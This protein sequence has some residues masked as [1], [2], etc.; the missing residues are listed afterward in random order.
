[1]HWLFLGALV[2][3]LLVAALAC[4]GVW[5]Y[6]RGLGRE[7]ETTTGP[8]AVVILP[9]RGVPP[10]LD[11]LWAALQ[12]Q[13]YAPWRLI[14]AVE[15]RDDPAFAALSRLV[16]DDHAPATEIVVA[17]LASDT[18]QK[19]HN[20]LAA[21]GRLQPQDDIVVFA[22]A[23]IVPA[24][25]WLARLVKP[26]LDPKI[27][28]VSGYRWFMPQDQNL[29]S[30]FVAVCNSSICTLP[31]PRG[32]SLAW[33]GSMAL[34]RTTLDSLDIARW[35]R[36]SIIDDL[37]LGRAV[38]AAGGDVLSPRELLVPSPVSYSWRDGI[39]FGRRQYALLRVYA[40]GHWLLAGAATTV[41]VIG[42]V[43]GLSLA[44][45]G[46]L[47]AIAVVVGVIALDRIRAALRRRVVRELWG[48]SAPSE[49]RRTLWL[50]RWATPF[51][52]LFHAAIVWSSLFQRNIDWGGRT[53]R[54][55][56]PQRLTILK[57]P[58][59]DRDG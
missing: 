55:D 15:S 33:G 11:A 24:Q 7:I 4:F 40:P 21:L 8:S 16:S 10:V 56:G 34:R 32:L 18:G 43:V 28:L 49:L 37:Q 27:A 6:Q 52:L 51:W 50:D 45:T 39:A 36:G 48:A 17:G 46:D 22:D 57:G 35:W 9:V 12:A 53:Y 30:A 58:G 31:K 14:F 42:W 23:D 1:V 47:T 26:L 44:A 38:R 54:L 41:P 13:D 29:A 3:W 20:Q 25:D 59:S 19:V 5:H 2:A